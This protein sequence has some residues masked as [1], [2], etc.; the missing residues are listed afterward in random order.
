MTEM[1]R[2]GVLLGA[3]ASIA[4]ASGCANGVASSGASTIDARVQATLNYLYQTYPA[5]IDLRDKAAGL[6]VMPLITKAALGAGGAYGRGALVVNG[7]TVDYYSSAQ[8]SV[9][10]Q[11][12]AQQY[13]HV[14]FFMTNEALY[15]FRTSAGW[16][17]GAD[18]EY[19]YSDRGGNLTATTITA[20]SPVI[21]LIF[22][23]A[24]LL[25]GASLDGTKYTRIIP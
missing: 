13:A 16:E 3:A 17:A 14:L 24:G 2:R 18:I 22:G 19:A 10:F 4:A 21:G 9:G 7:A 5:T 25:A 12:G 8:A 1:T 23:Q 15:N 20:T 11:I 6:L